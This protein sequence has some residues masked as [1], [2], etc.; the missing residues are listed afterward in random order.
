MVRRWSSINELN[1]DLINFKKFKKTSRLLVFRSSVYFKRFLIKR[2]KFKRKSIARWKHKTNWSIYFNVL[3]YWSGDY[4]F[5]RQVARFQFF[6]KIF[7]SNFVI[8]DFN[9][10]RARHAK[11]FSTFS[12]TITNASSKKLIYY[13]YSKRFTIRNKICRNLNN[14]TSYLPYPIVVENDLNLLPVYTS[15]QK[16]LYPVNL[17]K[18]FDFVN[19]HYTLF[20]ITLKQVVELYKV[21]ILINYFIFKC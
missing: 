11:M 21:L 6:N 4:H 3:K 12:N 9:Y 16:L 20:E 13:F 19:T 18:N 8:Y 2:T 14:V 10:I 15:H 7:L 17:I 5:S 1:I